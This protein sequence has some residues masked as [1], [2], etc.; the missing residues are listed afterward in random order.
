MIKDFEKGKLEGK[1]WPQFS[2]QETRFDDSVNQRRSPVP[3]LEMYTVC[4]DQK[5]HW[6]RNKWVKGAPEEWKRFFTE[7]RRLTSPRFFLI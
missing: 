5:M 6:G 3:A 7:K 1:V 4:T 2:N